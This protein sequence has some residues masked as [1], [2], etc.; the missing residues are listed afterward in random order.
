MPRS[1]AAAAPLARQPAATQPEP[2]LQRLASSLDDSPRMLAQRR[3]IASLFG[4]RGEEE[5]PVAANGVV[6][7][8]FLIGDQKTNDAGQFVEGADQLAQEAQV[9]LG[10]KPAIETAWKALPAHHFSATVLD[11]FRATLLAAAFAGRRVMLPA[12]A[13]E[14]ERIVQHRTQALVP[15]AD[16]ASPAGVGGTLA[17]T[18]TLGEK[19][20]HSEASYTRTVPMAAPA[21]G[22]RQ[23]SC[24]LGVNN[25]GRSEAGNDFNGFGCQRFFRAAGASPCCA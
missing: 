10:L 17:T 15:L 25:P 1:P 12:A 6:Q 7:G 23:L 3:Q 9:W 24:P 14:L 11:E 4:P 8:Y 20:K 19:E 13:A 2:T 21:T 22:R 16:T 18:P 5:A